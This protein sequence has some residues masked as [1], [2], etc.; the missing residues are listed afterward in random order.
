MMMRCAAALIAGV[1]LLAGCGGASNYSAPSSFMVS[2]AAVSAVV[3]QAVN[4]T[5]SSPGLNGSPI[6]GS[7]GETSSYIPY[8]VTKRAGIKND[9]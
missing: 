7:S 8:T 3:T 5:A 6:V 1:S 4:H 2:N 9:I